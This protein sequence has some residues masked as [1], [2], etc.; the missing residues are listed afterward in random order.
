LKNTYENIPFA[1]I[2]NL[3]FKPVQTNVMDSFVYVTAVFY[4]YY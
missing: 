2:L 4:N 1:F 3:P